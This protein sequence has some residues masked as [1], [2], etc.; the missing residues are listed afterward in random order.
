MAC[1]DAVEDPIEVRLRC[2]WSTKRRLGAQP[3]MG[4]FQN[5]RAELHLLVVLQTA[6]IRV[7]SKAGAF[8]SVVYHRYAT[9]LGIG[10]WPGP[11]EQKDPRR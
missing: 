3:P 8:W 10:L 2:L 9:L 4:S 5:A 6:H 11:R 1:V 7:G